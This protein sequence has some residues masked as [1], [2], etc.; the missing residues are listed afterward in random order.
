M[1][2]RIED[3]IQLQQQNLAVEA[4]NAYIKLLEESLSE[5]DFYIVYINVF[6]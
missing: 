1:D 5:T 4:K 3:I 2:K 6:N